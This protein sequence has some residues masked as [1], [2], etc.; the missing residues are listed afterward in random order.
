MVYILIFMLTDNCSTALCEHLYWISPK[1]KN[2]YYFLLHKNPIKE[3]VNF[4]I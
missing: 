4:E 1:F 3:S 2:K